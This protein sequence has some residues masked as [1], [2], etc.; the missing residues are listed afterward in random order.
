MTTLQDEQSRALTAI[1]PGVEKNVTA[2]LQRWRADQG[3]EEWEDYVANM[4]AVCVFVANPQT[5][6]VD[7]QFVA[8][9]AL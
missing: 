5:N 9:S 4:H 8:W 7:A 3:L 1:Y 6:F 2:L